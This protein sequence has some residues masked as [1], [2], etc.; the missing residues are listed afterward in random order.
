MIR[1]GETEEVV[2]SFEFWV[3]SYHPVP[4]PKKPEEPKRP[5]EQERR[6]TAG[7]AKIG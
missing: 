3:L 2:L 4:G 5:D 7:E 1:P 6:K